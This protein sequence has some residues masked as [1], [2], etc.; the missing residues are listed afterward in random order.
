MGPLGPRSGQDVAAAS[1]LLTPVPGVCPVNL[2]RKGDP[3]PQRRAEIRGQARMLCGRGNT[4]RARQG[5][6]S[7][8][9]GGTWA[10]GGWPLCGCF[11]RVPD[12][13]GVVRPRQ[14]SCLHSK[15]AP[16]ATVLRNSMGTTAPLLVPVC[17]RHSHS[18]SI[19]LASHVSP[20]GVACSPVAP[21]SRVRGTPSDPFLRGILRQQSC[22]TRDLSSGVEVHHRLSKHCQVAA[23]PSVRLAWL[24]V[25]R[26]HGSHFA[27]RPW[28][29]W[30][31]CVLV[32]CSWDS[33]AREF[34]RTPALPGVCG[35]P[36]HP[37]DAVARFPT[38]GPSPWRLPPRSPP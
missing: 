18:R 28:S 4:R 14:A 17:S 3:W 7:C 27:T 15:R 35:S 19:S 9:G 31:A 25:W 29:L 8:H 21:P 37:V 1:S 13:D 26:L 30:V 11:Q 6:A 22:V 5:S 34:R 38:A 12:C 2:S 33:V 20:G 32:A 23:S 36:W 16:S 24:T 10:S